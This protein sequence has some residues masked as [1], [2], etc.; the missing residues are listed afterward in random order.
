M[1]GLRTQAA[2][3]DASDR[4]WRTIHTPQQ[5]LTPVREVVTPD[6]IRNA[7]PAEWDARMR[8]L[9]GDDWEMQL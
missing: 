3:R 6:F 1:S 4:E 8:E 2:C 5:V 9:H 7:T